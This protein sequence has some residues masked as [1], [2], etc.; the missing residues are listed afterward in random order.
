MKND[1]RPY[2]LAVPADTQSNFPQK[3]PEKMSD[4]QDFYF[5]KRFLMIK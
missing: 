4:F 5:T 3:I 2:V 1:G